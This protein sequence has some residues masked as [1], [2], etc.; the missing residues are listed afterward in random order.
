MSHCLRDE[1]LDEHMDYKCVLFIVFEMSAML[2]FKKLMKKR[3][4]IVPDYALQSEHYYYYCYVDVLRRL[5]A[6]AMEL[7]SATMCP[8]MGGMEA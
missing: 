3:Q 7:A 8:G 2:Q 5:V 1:W 4:K 6:I